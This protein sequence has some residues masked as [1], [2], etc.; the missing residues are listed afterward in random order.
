MRASM[1]YEIRCGTCG[2]LVDI[3][4]FGE[5][6]GG[7]GKLPKDKVPVEHQKQLPIRVSV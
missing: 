6:A 2:E 1:C 7:C 3:E 4:V 5:H